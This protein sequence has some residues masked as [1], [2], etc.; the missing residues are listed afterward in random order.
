MLLYCGWPQDYLTGQTEED[1]GHIIKEAGGSFKLNRPS[2]RMYTLCKI[3]IFLQSFYLSI[4]IPICHILR[5]TL[6]HMVKD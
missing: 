6:N 1:D 4:T 5:I 3:C 2:S